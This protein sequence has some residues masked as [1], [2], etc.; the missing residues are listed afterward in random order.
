ME[1][2]NI[3]KKLLEQN[4]ELRNRIAFHVSFPDYKRDELMYFRQN[5]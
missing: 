4:E 5:S 1:Q 2:D 3:I